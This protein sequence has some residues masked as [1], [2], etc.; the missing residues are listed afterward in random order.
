MT[1]TVS[2]AGLENTIREYLR[3]L[4][5]PAS[6]NAAQNA[7]QNGERS[8]SP[9]LDAMATLFEARAILATHFSEKCK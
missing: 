4:T 8:I 3:P 7:T 2:A 1:R 9:A 6:K 5:I